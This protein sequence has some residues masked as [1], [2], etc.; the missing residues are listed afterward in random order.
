MV[1]SIVET[2]LFIAYYRVSD[3]KQGDGKTSGTGYGIE[4]QERAVGFLRQQCSA[5]V[6]DS[7]T[8]I[9]TGTAKRRRPTLEAALAKCRATGATLG[10][11]KLDR[12][13]RDVEFIAHLMKSGVPFIC[14]DYPNADPLMLHMMAAVAEH[15]AKV[16][17]ERTKAGLKSARLKGKLLGSA[18]P[19]HWEG[20]E[21]RRGVFSNGMKKFHQSKSEAVRRH[22]SIMLPTIRMMLSNGSTQAEIV[23]YLND[24]GQVT[25]TK[26]PFSQSV[27]QTVIARYLDTKVPA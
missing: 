17:S 12:L 25:S 1:A 5:T 8:E 9:E 13:A 6:L 14:C 11:A 20:K 4:A 27:L 18:R 7:Y 26:R 19:G 23:K 21:H 2:L 24:G 22:Y 3:K 10:V 16:I 15:E